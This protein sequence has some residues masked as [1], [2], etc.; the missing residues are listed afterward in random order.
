MFLQKRKIYKKNIKR[1]FIK[2]SINVLKKKICRRLKKITTK[3][4]Q[5]FHNIKKF[6][7]KFRI[8]NIF[9]NMKKF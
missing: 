2:F 4:F 3:T 6:L 7:S 9:K 5:K 8:E 1:K